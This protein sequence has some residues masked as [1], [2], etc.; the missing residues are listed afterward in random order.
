MGI[1]ER[2]RGIER[3]QRELVADHGGTAADVGTA[4]ATAKW[5]FWHPVVVHTVD[6]IEPGDPMN[7]PVLS[8]FEFTQATPHSSRLKAGAS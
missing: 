5:H 3:I 7:M 6:A 8:A 1:R 4:S 2:K